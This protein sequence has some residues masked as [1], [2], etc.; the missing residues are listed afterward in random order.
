MLNHLHLMEALRIFKRARRVNRQGFRKF[1]GNAEEISSE[2]VRQCFNGT[3]FQTSIGHFNQFYIRDFAYS[4]T[5][6]MN[7]GYQKEVRKTLEYA[8]YI[9]SKE[10]VLANAITPSGKPV[11]IFTYCPDSL[12]L[13]L[14]SIRKSKADYLVKK[15]KRFIEAQVRY[16]YENVFDEKK[17]IVKNRR[18]SSIKDNAIRQRACYDNSMLIMLSDE[19]SNLGIQNPFTNY[20]LR[21]I[22]KKKYWTGQYFLEDLSGKKNIAGDAQVFPFWCNVFN[23]KKMKK[24]A[25]AKVKEKRLDTP[26]PLKYTETKNEIKVMFPLNII[27]SDYETNT[28]WLHLGLCFLDILDSKKELG[29]HLKNLEELIERTKTFPE[30]LEPNGEIFKKFHY[31]SD[32]GM[33]WAAKYL[34]L[35]KSIK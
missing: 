26:L 30:V 12:P 31:V 17:G 9:F 1:N 11:H 13:L 2:I 15:Y 7:L 14:Y 8:L 35:K 21:E 23:D 25:I 4:I 3:F 22:M 18:F 24:R 6:L 10:K 28:I 34:H 27:L 16:Y 20:N 29:K 33:L 32:E 19:L 5:P